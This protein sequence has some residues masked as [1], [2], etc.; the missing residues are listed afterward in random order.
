M[1][2]TLAVTSLLIMLAAPAIPCD[3]DYECQLRG[4]WACN[5]LYEPESNEL[6][7]CI[8]YVSELF[9]ER[10]DNLE[11]QEYLDYLDAQDSWKMN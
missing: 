8:E 11:I 9:G 2:K 7:E 5:E 4:I 6:T 1:I 3:T 10:I